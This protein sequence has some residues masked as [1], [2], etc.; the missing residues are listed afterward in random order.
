MAHRLGSLVSVSPA[1]EFRPG[2]GSNLGGGVWDD[3][4]TAATPPVGNTKF[5]ILHFAGVTLNAGDNLAVPLGN[6]DTDVF[7]VASGPNFW[8]RPIKGGTVAIRFV[9]GGSGAGR[10]PLTEYGRGEGIVNNGI[11]GGS[12]ISTSGGNAN[13]DV[14]MLDTPYVDP[15]HFN[16]GGVCPPGARHWANVGSLPPG[17]MRNA[18]RST[19]MFLEVGEGKVS[20]CSAA[21]I[22]PDLI[23]TAAHCV[24][25]GSVVPSGSF[26]LDYQTDAAG[27]RPAGYNPKFHKLKRLVKSGFATAPMGGGVL[28]YAII[29]IETPPG[30][31]GLPP[32]SIRADLPSVGAPPVGE[33]VFLIHHPRGAT[34]KV[35]RRTTDPGCYV[36]IIQNNKIFF[37]GD[38]D[39]GS[40]G[41]PLF[42]LMGRIVGV[43]NWAGSCPS[44]LADGTA[45]GISAQAAAA[46]LVDMASAPPPAADVDVVLVFDKSGSMSLPGLGGG[47]K[48]QQAR[49]AAALF[50]D[51][52][53][54]DRTHR[55]GLV[56]FSTTAS[57][58]EALAPIATNRDAL[59][60]PQPN[61]N[62]GAIAAITPTAMTTIGG[63]LRIGRQQ[64]TSSPS[65]NTPAIL[66]LT[67][68]LQNTPPMIAEVEAELGNTRL[69]VIGFGTEGQ[70]NG[71]LLT[72]LA[73]DH[74]GI[75]TRANEG[76]ALK[77][78]FV[79]CFGNIFQTGIASDPFF[80]FPAGSTS[81]APMPLS[82]CDEESITVVLSWKNSAQN[83]SLSVTTPTGNTLTRVTPGVFS[84]S[85]ATW[86]YFRLELPFNAEREGTWQVA[87][88][89]VDGGGELAPPLT[90]EPFFVTVTA[91]GG[92]L[93]KPLDPR[94]RYYTGDA[95]NPQVVL[96]YPVGYQ[97]PDANVTVEIES[98]VNGTGNVLTGTGLGA[99]T[100]VGGDQLDARSSTLIQLE[101]AQG[102]TLI[103]TATNIYPLFD[104]GVRDGDDALEPDGVFGNPLADIL[105][106]E[107]NY[108]FHARATYGHECTGTRETLWSTYVSVGI[109]PGKSKVEIVATADV[110]GGKRQ[111]TIR[112]TPQDRYDNPLGPGRVDQFGVSGT[113]GSTPNGPAHDRGNGSYDV[114]VL[115]DPAVAPQPGVVIAQ[116]ERPPVTIAPPGAPPVEKP[117]CPIWLCV[118][119]VFLLLIAVLVILLR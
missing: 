94:R 33:E 103:G 78:F 9:D 55:A 8:T 59:I 100:V 118:L 35:S 44:T 107:G 15:P 70:L 7:T 54:L 66:L 85:G 38:V 89:R 82:I 71:P 73:R 98:P 27:N 19:G 31:L 64:L 17:V 108:T 30:G 36:Q 91:V 40:S 119:L 25:A 104:D 92:P 74:G 106:N 13:G 43:N 22:G 84:S 6:G 23:L 10:A 29:Q 50:I 39:N 95:I 18:A 34:K 99:A 41:S 68:G 102:G 46:I 110:G 49:E 16:P 87:A 48:I 51:L 105:R 20:S 76:L 93:M 67:D 72:R 28:D 42:D 24:A 57:V 90:E 101:Q 47:T 52:L 112:L 83:L 79:L 96:R 1:R 11:D 77:K 65:A 26:T 61:R 5:M 97:V 109:D 69:C 12:D 21:I 117:C 37:G 3:T 63:G 113:I 32:L 4:F 56:T 86:V 111:V 60:G 62:G 115:W 14:F 58:A 116:P 114:G 2:S 88:S 45:A 81:M 53:R 80:V 75:Y